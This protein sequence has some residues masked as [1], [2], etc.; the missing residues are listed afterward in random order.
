MTERKRFQNQTLNSEDYE[1]IEV[2]AK[3]V[4]NGG[5]NSRY[6]LPCL[7]RR[8]KV[9]TCPLEESQKIKK[10]MKHTNLYEHPYINYRKHV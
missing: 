7:W 3:A 4:K 9:W 1:K 2:G 8:Q 10:G 5:N 6:N